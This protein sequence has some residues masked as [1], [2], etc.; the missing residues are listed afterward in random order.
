MYF[1]IIALA[2]SLQS[3]VLCFSLCQETSLADGK[4]MNRTGSTSLTGKSSNPACQTGLSL[5]T[6]LW[7]VCHTSRSGTGLWIKWLSLESRDILLCSWQ[8]T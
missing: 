8:D 1:Q 5:C 7:R 4:V 2:N 3:V 6:V